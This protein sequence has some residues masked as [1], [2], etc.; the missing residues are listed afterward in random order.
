M[1]NLDVPEMGL[2]QYEMVFRENK[3]EGDDLSIRIFIQ[4][5]KI[6]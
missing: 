5:K 2:F 4:Y 3:G 6:I 1:K